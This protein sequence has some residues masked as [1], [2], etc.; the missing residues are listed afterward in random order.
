MKSFT[1]GKNDAGQRLDRFLTKATPNLPHSML[2]KGI[3][4][5]NIKVNRKR[6]TIDQRLMEGDLVELYL[7]TYGIY[8]TLIVRAVALNEGIFGS[9]AD[10]NVLVDFDAIGNQGQVNAVY[11]N[12]TNDALFEKYENLFATYFPTIE[13]GE[14]NG[15]QEVVGIVTNNTLLFSIAL[16]FLVATLMLIL[17]TAYLIVSRNRMSEMIIFKSAGATPTQVAFIML[18]EVLFY[19]LVGASIGLMLGRVAMSI[20]ATALLP[21]APHAVTY[22]WW[23]FVV[24]FIISVL[25][26]LLSTLV[27]VIQVSKK[28]VRELSA[29]GFKTTKDV[30]LVTLIISSVI[31]V[32]ICVAYAFLSGIALLILSVALIIAI[33]FWIYCAI[34]LVTKLIGKLIKK[35]SKGGPTYLSAISISRSSAMQTVTTLIAVVIA[36]SFLITQVVG[37]VKEATIPF[38]ERYSADYVVVSQSGLKPNEFDEIKGT[39][40]NVEGITGAGWFNGTDYYL[41]DSEQEFT[42]YGVNDFWMLEH[43]TTGLEGDTEKLWKEVENPI[44]LNQNVVMMIGAKIGDEISVSPI[45]EDYKNEKHTFTLV[46]IDRSISQWDMVA[47][48]NYN[49][50]YRMNDKA[51]FLITATERSAETFVELRDA[52]ENLNYPTT[53]ALTFE[54]WAYAEQKSFAGVESLMTILQI[55]VWFISLM[56]VMNISIVT[57]YDRRAEFRLYKLSGMSSSDYMKFSLG[58]GIVAGLSGGILGFIAGYSVNMLVPGL[59]SIIQRYKGFNAMPLELI[60]TFLIGV[61]AF[62]ILWMLIALVNRKNTVKSINERHLNG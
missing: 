17:F 11:I 19:A 62:L 5:K 35:V 6:A 43:C 31:V 59:G 2:Y 46:G 23:K 53:F 36:F 54:E 3:R 47:Y 24:S 44:V 37:I 61:S 26:S 15:Y 42:I 49:F 32:A 18:S 13:C 29:T 22:P 8:A 16:V 28:T 4:T 60:Y 57:V 1:I 27:P 55:L 48:C 34:G 51:N 39:A 56:G 33:A 40:L 45:A 7:P 41:P 30:K 38:R 10:M 14:G 12:F 21:M 9:T 52:I 25:V 58:E 50:T 20:V